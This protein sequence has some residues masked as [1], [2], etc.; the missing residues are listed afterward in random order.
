ML[1]YS[2]EGPEQS[3]TLTMADLYE[4]NPPL[5]CGPV[6]ITFYDNLE[7]F[8]INS[9]A[10]R[11][12]EDTES[13]LTTEFFLNQQNDQTT[14][15]THDIY[16]KLNLIDYFRDEADYFE[17]FG[18]YAFQVQIEGLSN[19]CAVPEPLG[20]VPLSCPPPDANYFGIGKV[21]YL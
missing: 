8:S 10:F 4:L 11:W 15:K 18:T 1:E 2:L 7:D 16:Y 5:D 3:I 17:S 14:I 21:P 6:E 19:D 12:V 9:I 20:P 13:F